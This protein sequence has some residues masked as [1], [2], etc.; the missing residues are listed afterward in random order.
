MSTGV[1]VEYNDSKLT[2][3]GVKAGLK[4]KTYFVRG[5]VNG[6]AFKRQIGKV[7]LMTFEEAYQQAVD[8]L[9]D[10][11]QGI[12][13][14]DRVAQAEDAE[15]IT[16]TNVLRKYL[17]TRKNLKTS[18]REMYKLE[19]DRYLSDWLDL[20]MHSIT[21][22][23][24]VERHA[25]IGTKSKAMADCTFRIVRAL[26]NFGMDM[27]EDTITRNPV[28]RLSAVKAWYKVPRKTSFV[29]PTMLPV[30]IQAIRKHPGLVSDYLE[31]LLFTGIRSGSEIAKLQIEHVDLKEKSITLFDTKTQK[32]LR[33]PVCASTMTVLNRRIADARQHKTPFLFYSFTSKTSASGHIT[34]VRTGIKQVLTG[35]GLDHITPHDLRRTFLTYADELDISKVVQKRLVGHA[36]PTDV[37]DGYI[38]LTMDR[39]R[40]AVNRIEKFILKHAAKTATP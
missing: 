38:V 23:M 17:A 39:L 1:P 15:K 37:T 40:D 12:S 16:L 24:I 25:L 36:I 9:S 4:S 29:K 30:F 21:S 19:L 13:P 35:T 31:A 28:K 5:S 10:A 20:P 34:D 3:F 2:G 26:Y 6:K 8:I 32:E 7:E 11:A 14:D 33:I 22:A 27:Y 18:T